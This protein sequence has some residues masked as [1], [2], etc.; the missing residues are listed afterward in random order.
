MNARDR[1]AMYD[2]LS[3]I[4]TTM[5]FLSCHMTEHKKLDAA[6]NVEHAILLIDEAIADVLE[7]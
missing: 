3:Y 2:E 5:V 4:R 1:Q 7:D 6:L